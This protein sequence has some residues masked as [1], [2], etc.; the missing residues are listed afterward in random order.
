MLLLG[1][2]AALLVIYL[3]LWVA[4]DLWS[5][6]GELVEGSFSAVIHGVAAAIAL[7]SFPIVSAVSAYRAISVTTKEIGL[8]V[9]LTVLY[10]LSATGIGMILIF[11]VFRK[12]HYWY[13]GPPF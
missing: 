5:I 9:F 3:I 6:H 4:L 2:Q 12:L 11:V 10:S 7:F 13:G 8:K 1:S